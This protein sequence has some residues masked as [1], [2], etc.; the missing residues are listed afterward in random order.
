M[1]Q[2]PLLNRRIQSI[3]RYLW[4]CCPYAINDGTNRVP[5]GERTEHT[6]TSGAMAMEIRGGHDDIGFVCQDPNCS[7]FKGT[8][9]TQVMIETRSQQVNQVTGEY[10]IIVG[11]EP[12]PVCSGTYFW[13]K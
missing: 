9:T 6:L 12:I 3:K 11:Q 5:L 7:F 1:A 10:T 8:A 13:E 4:R 2:A